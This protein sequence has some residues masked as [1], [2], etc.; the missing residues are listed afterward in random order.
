MISAPEHQKHEQMKE[1]RKLSGK[2]LQQ[3]KRELPQGKK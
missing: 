2:Y 3:P 1:T